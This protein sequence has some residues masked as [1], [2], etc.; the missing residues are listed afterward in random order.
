[1]IPAIVRPSKKCRRDHPK[2]A[3]T[4]H[5]LPLHCPIF[6]YADT[7]EKEMVTPVVPSQFQVGKNK[8][9]HKP[10]KATFSF[11]TGQAMFKSVDWGPVGDQPASGQ[12]YRRDDVMR[13]AQQLLS[14]L[15][16]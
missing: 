10:T 5:Y 8:I 7:K 1:V 13:V 4:L 2:A 9:V 16:R 6:A 14:K 3:T 15:P 12:D 11:D